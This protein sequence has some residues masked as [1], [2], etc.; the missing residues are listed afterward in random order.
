MGI[1]GPLRAVIRPDSGAA[2]ISIAVIG[3]PASPALDGVQP[4]MPCMSSG[5]KN[6]VPKT[7]KLIMKPLT[8]A[9]VST[10]SLKKCRS[11]IGSVV[12]SSTT[13]KAVRATT[14]P[15]AQPSTTPSVQPRAGPST[16]V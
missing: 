16:S 10:R 7:P 2:T 11:S 4:M 14:A 3:R 13:T 8:T 5:R 1:R 6:E 15:A 12:R 9:P